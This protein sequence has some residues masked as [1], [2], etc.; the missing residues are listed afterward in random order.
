VSESTSQSV[1]LGR[2]DQSYSHYM[3]VILFGGW[4]E[5]FSQSDVHLLVCQSAIQ[6]VSHYVSQSASLIRRRNKPDS[7]SADLPV[8]QSVS[9]SV[10]ESKS[11]ALNWSVG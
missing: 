10:S 11:Q 7:H 1:L 9:Q 5:A 4:Q 2:Y 3:S 6:S 8:S